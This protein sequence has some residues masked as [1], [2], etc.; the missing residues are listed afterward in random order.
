MSMSIATRQWPFVTYGTYVWR[1]SVAS[2][3]LLSLAQSVKDEGGQL[4][5]LWGSDDRHH[6]AGFSLHSVFLVA[7]GLCWAVTS[8][9][10]EHPHYPDLSALFPA[11]DRQQRATYDLMGLVADGAV[12]V[13]KWLRHAAWPA[14]SFPL[15]HDFAAQP[16]SGVDDYPFIQ[17][18]GEGVH[19]VAVGPVHAG[20][21]EPGHFRFSVIGERVLRLAERFGYTH[22]GVEKRF[23]GLS[24][25]QGARLAGRISGDSHSAYAMAYCV[26][27]ESATGTAIPGR[28]RWL[29]GLWL[30]M[31]R[32]ANHLGDLGSLGNDAGL[33]FGFVQFWRLKEKWLRLS[34]QL[35][36]HRYLFDCMVPGGVAFNLVQAGILVDA[37]GRLAEE[38]SRL[39]EIYDEHAGLQDRFTN[40]G[41][42][43]PRLAAELGLTGMAGRASAQAWDARTQF[44]VAP[45]DVL[46]VKM[47]THQQGDVLARVEV[48]FDEVLES[49]RLIRKIVHDMPGGALRVPLHRN[50]SVQEGL[51]WVEGWR[52]GVIV[53][54]RIG[55][56]GRLDRVHPHDPSWQNWPVLESGI[57]GNI[58]ADFPLINKSF[59]LSY[60]GVDL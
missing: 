29:R 4:L 50:N 42:V 12:D 36:G 14:D 38:V 25:E 53:A 1:G 56:D 19:E 55:L 27:V 49:L 60:S 45:Y 23:E 46:D 48:R 11:A 39:R 6:A 9:A 54:V 44:P 21:I 57:L 10:A 58:V 31:E 7:A 5:A 2:A 8:L 47:A 13:R 15:R 22:K 16:T 35:F 52:G 17:V 41:I 51:G 26:A 40:T 3:D 33:A 18:D 34:E 43:S 32:I 28:A 59:N 30:E 20:T 37:A 24:L